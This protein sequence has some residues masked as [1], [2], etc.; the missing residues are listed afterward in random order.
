[1]VGLSFKADSVRPEPTLFK[2]RPE[3]VYVLFLVFLF[4]SLPA[5]LTIMSYS[6]MAES[7]K[8]AIFYEFLLVSGIS[9]GE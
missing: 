5:G 9:S 2:L 8:L 7:Y 3:A 1:M 6:L 4:L